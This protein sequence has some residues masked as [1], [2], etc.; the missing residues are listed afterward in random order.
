VSNGRAGPS[1][2]NP[3][4]DQVAQVLAAVLELLG[5]VTV[6]QAS[7]LSARLGFDG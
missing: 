6:E 2:L 4:P 3:D 7:E 1:P 5:R